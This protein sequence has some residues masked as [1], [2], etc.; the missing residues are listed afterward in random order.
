[1]KREDR[2]MRVILD[3]EMA[4]VL[5]KLGELESIERGDRLCRFC[6]IPMTLDN[7]QMIVPTQSR[8]FEYVCS[9]PACVQTYL[10]EGG[11]I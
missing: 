2:E 10:D 9:D 11:Q 3:E 8:S 6:G 1:M 5:A 4:S 7:I